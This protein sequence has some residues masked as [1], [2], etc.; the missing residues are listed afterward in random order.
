MKQTTS[1][2]EN[3]RTP[4]T[5]K[6]N[7]TSKTSY[8]KIRAINCRKNKPLDWKELDGDKGV[9][10]APKAWKRVAIGLDWIGWEEWKWRELFYE[11][12]GRRN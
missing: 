12:I 8:P 1:I 10:A 2:V 9:T 6:R 3:R 11:E 4:F 7:P 5:Y